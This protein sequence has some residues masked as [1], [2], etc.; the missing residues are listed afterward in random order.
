MPA[1]LQ[2]HTTRWIEKSTED[3]QGQNRST[4]GACYGRTELSKPSVDGSYVS[5]SETD[6]TAGE[7]QK[8][9]GRRPLF[10]D[11]FAPSLLARAKHLSVA[12]AWDRG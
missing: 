2:P 10:H 1:H 3:I 12:A 6:A 5:M 8:G 11:V 7:N 4:A 9:H